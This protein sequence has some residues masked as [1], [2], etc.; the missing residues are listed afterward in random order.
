MSL[1][2]GRTD[3]SVVSSGLERNNTTNEIECRSCLKCSLSPSRRRPQPGFSIVLELYRP[4]GNHVLS[5]GIGDFILEAFSCRVE[6]AEEARSH[7]KLERGFLAELTHLRRLRRCYITQSAGTLC[8]DVSLG[9]LD[10]RAW[11]GSVCVPPSLISV[12]GDLIR[13]R[14]LLPVLQLTYRTTLLLYF[15]DCLARKVSA[16]DAE[17]N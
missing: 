16:H 17:A 5:K 14:F 10:W 13:L 3:S 1:S 4:L 6:S 12:L 9:C 15:L 8:A 7:S 11:T 2:T